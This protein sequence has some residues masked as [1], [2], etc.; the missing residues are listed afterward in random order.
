MTIGELADPSLYLPTPEK[1]FRQLR[2]DLSSELQNPDEH[3]PIQALHVVAEHVETAPQLIQHILWLHEQ[4]SVAGPD[5]EHHR[6]G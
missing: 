6:S 1:L 4:G 5:Q 2:D 3:H